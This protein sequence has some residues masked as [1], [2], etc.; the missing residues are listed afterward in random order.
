[1]INSR[2]VKHRQVSLPGWF[3]AS[4]ICGCLKDAL[5]AS[6]GY[7]TKWR[8]REIHDPPREHRTGILSSPGVA[9]EAWE[10]E[11]VFSFLGLHFWKK[12]GNKIN[13][14]HGLKD[15]KDFSVR[16]DVVGDLPEKELYKI[17]RRLCLELELSGNE[18]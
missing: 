1:M 6:S 10:V 8:W 7:K 3:G 17:E 18:A 9:F 13:I 5:A 16:L 11:E 4:T 2:G 14:R 12:T 15:V